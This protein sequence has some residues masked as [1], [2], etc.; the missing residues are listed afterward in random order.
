MA[1]TDKPYRNQR[2][3]DIVFAVS[4]I[5]ML[6]ST[7]VDARRR[8]QPRIQGGAAHLPRRG[9]GARTSGRCSASCPTPAEVEK[10]QKEVADKRQ[11]RGRRPRQGVQAE[12]QRLTAER[13]TAHRRHTGRSRP[14][15][16]RNRAFTTSTSRSATRPASADE[17]A[18]GTRGTGQ[19]PE[20]ELDRA[21]DEP[22]RGPEGGRCRPMR[23]TRTRVT[24]KPVTEA[25][26]DLADAEDAAEEADRP[27]STAS[28]S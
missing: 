16:T 28:P 13:D 21:P 1:A 9:I 27:T 25:E 6:F 4:C 10:L 12:D 7:R 5:L 20:E 8:L 17:V 3:L 14:I 19:G 18:Q 24:D 22:G 11:A 26:N 23:S 15:S 2:T